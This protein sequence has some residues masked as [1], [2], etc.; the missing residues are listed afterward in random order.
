M[1]SRQ[2][3]ENA[4]QFFVLLGMLLAVSLSGAGQNPPSGAPSVPSYTAP[5][6]P[7][8]V[9]ITPASGPGATSATAPGVTTQGPFQGSV[10][11]GQPTGT[12]LALSL[13]DAFARA[14]K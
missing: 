7:A 9:T 2:N 11:T 1:L 5:A 14:L 13:K 12:T 6:G 10:P 3:R 4:S 8:P